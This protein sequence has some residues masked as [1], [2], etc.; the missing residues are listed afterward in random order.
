ME[1]AIGLNR[2]MLGIVGLWPRDSK[3]SRKALL[4]KV[5]LLFNVITLVFIL[6]IPA[7]MSLIRVWGDMILVIDNLQYTLPLLITVL[8]I[9]IILC[10]KKAL[11]SLIDMIIKDWIKAKMKEERRIML[12]RAKNTRV[13]TLCGAMMILFTLLITIP[14]LLF[15]FTLRHITNL[16]DPGK[17][18]II[19]AYY[20]HDVSKSPH[21]ELTFLIQAISLTLSG[22]SYTG[23]DNFLGL[24][25]LHICGQ[26]EN[27][28]LRLMNLR[29]NPNFKAALK[30][31]VKD[32][33]RLIRSTQVLD[34]IFNLM[35]LGLFFFFG[36]LFCLQGFLI[37]NV[38]NKEG[39]LS[40]LQL[41]SYILATVCVL[42]H[43]CLYCAVGE[44]LVSQSE[45]IHH[46]MYEY[47][48]YNLEPK[49]ARNLILIMLRAKNRST[50]QREKSFQ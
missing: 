3:N 16:T 29:N 12:K 43:T 15:G 26:I 28:H 14:T 4:S 9:S 8:K 44:F 32:H 19:Q 37:I 13:L 25:T 10:N 24:L 5:R 49:T 45:K 39:Q 20:L 34:D 46:V 41:T 18:L 2:S 22:L 30:F 38:V 42:M 1:W 6:T 36:I 47:V 23:I 21:F 48:W 27:L 50:L 33:I 11:T 17:P 31:N 7:L 40:F 35:L